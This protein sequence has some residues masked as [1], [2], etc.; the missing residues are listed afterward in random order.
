VIGSNTA[1][2]GVHVFY[3][4]DFC[5]KISTRW[6]VAAIDMMLHFEA[7]CTSGVERMGRED[8]NVFSPVFRHALDV[9]LWTSQVTFDTL[10]MLCYSM[11][12]RKKLLTRS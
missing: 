9:A 1:R 6:L 8:D 2:V 4:V 12:F 11:G 3:L 5:N 10:L 7:F